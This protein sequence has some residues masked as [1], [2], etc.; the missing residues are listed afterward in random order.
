MS[1]RRVGILLLVSIACLL[2]FT[3]WCSL[4][5]EPV[6]CLYYGT[7]KLNGQNIAESVIV[8]AWIGDLHWTAQ[9]WNEGVESWYGV[10]IPGDSASTPAKDGGVPVDTITFK[11]GEHVADQT[12]PWQE[13]LYQQNS[14]LHLTVTATTVQSHNDLPLISHYLPPTPTRT[15]TATVTATPSRTAT[16][17]WTVDVTPTVVTITQT[18]DT[19]LRGDLPNTSYGSEGELRLK[20]DDSKRVLI[21]FDLT[22]LPT[23]A[24]ITAAQLRL[25]TTPWRRPSGRWTC[26]AICSGGVG[27]E[28]DATWN[29]TT[30]GVAWGQPGAKDTVVDHVPEPDRRDDGQ[31]AY[32][33]VQ[34]ECHLGGAELG[35]RSR[36]QLWLADDRRGERGRVCFYSAQ[37]VALPPFRPQLVVSYAAASSLSRPLPVHHQELIVRIIFR[38]RAR[39]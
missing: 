8:T 28:N 3:P 27:S 19:Y 33:L 38:R 13:G 10:S 31:C 37:N 4:A 2:A 17:T 16:P 20:T 5:Q 22:S 11:V 15:A 34:L 39:S 36:Q 9:R 12:A 30:D 6:D 24:V 14:V 26:V 1:I 29:E 18:Q 21:R 25:R 32:D 7:V 35:C 23:N